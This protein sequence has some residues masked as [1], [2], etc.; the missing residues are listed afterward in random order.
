MELGVEVCMT[1]C[2]EEVMD[3]MVV[4]VSNEQRFCCH[5]LNVPDTL[6]RNTEM[7]V[8]SV[9]TR[10]NKSVHTNVDSHGQLWDLIY[11]CIGT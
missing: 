8:I 9:P 11:A 4:C 10:F 1:E 6:S 2:D 3:M 7:A 5:F